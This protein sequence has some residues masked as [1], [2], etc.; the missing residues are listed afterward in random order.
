MNDYLEILIRSL[1]AF[2]GVIFITRLV[3]KSQVGGLNIAD[4]VNGIVIGSIA[5][6]LATDLKTPAGL[7]AF[8]LLIFLVLTMAAEWVGVKYR[9][10]HKLLSDDPTIVVHNGVIL[11][12]NMHKMRYTVDDLT[13]QLRQKNVFNI[14]DVEYAIAEP[15]GELSV[16]LKSRVAPVTPQ[17]LQMPS[18][19][20]GVPSELVIDGVIIRQNLKQNNLEEDW[21]LGELQKQG[22]QSLQEVFYASLDQDGN[23]Y[24]DK[25][26]DKMA[27]TQDITDKLPGKMPQ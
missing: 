16:L 20:K 15:D 1:G 23:L 21:L 24:V 27:Y 6:S 7:Y 11:E 12:G 18:K 3:G 2:A 14:A 9:P 13:S 10:V 17:D 8:A 26:Q 19:Y 25:K 5:A 22:I 4:W